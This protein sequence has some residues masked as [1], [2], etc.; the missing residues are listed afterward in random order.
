MDHKFVHFS[1]QQLFHTNSLD[2]V[3]RALRLHHL[4][5]LLELESRLMTAPQLLYQNGRDI[6]L[7]IVCQFDSCDALR[8]LFNHSDYLVV[9]QRTLGRF[10]IAVL[11]NVGGRWSIQ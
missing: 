10:A 5:R 4:G 9:G 8:W 1:V 11:G 6:Y 3:L 7:L 2:V